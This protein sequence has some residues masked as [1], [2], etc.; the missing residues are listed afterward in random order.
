M[1]IPKELRELADHHLNYSDEANDLE[2]TRA[3]LCRVAASMFETMSKKI[4]QKESDR[5]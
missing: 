4:S 2:F 1:N 5:G 3:Q